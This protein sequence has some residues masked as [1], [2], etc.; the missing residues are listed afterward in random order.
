MCET[1]IFKNDVQ[2]YN[3]FAFEHFWDSLCFTTTFMK[4][5][6]FNSVVN[7]LKSFVLQ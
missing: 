7:K 1:C 6:G 2:L 3:I 4:Y 5:I